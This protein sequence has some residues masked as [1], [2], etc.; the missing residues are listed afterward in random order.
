MRKKNNQKIFEN[1]FHPSK[2]WVI[3]SEE[4]FNS[5]FNND[6]F[7]FHLFAFCLRLVGESNVYISRA[8]KQRIF[9]PF[10]SKNAVGY[11]PRISNLVN[12]GIIKE[13]IDDYKRK[14]YTLTEKANGTFV[15]TIKDD[16]KKK[17]EI[18]RRS[19]VI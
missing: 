2:V 10:G 12:A 6:V 9:R 3:I 5:C 17:L 16:F 4:V 13:T 11:E 14:Y 15:L 8:E 1:R 19:E 7:D 18:L